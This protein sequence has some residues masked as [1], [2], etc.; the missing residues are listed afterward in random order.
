MSSFLTSESSGRNL[1]SDELIR[2]L[3][4]NQ[5]DESLSEELKFLE[6]K[7][8]KESF[9]KKLRHSIEII[10]D[11]IELTLKGNGER[12]LCISFNGGKDCCVVLFLFYKIALKTGFLSTKHQFN[13]LI[14]K[15]SE[16][17]K[18]MDEF[19]DKIFREFY[20]NKDINKIV[21]DKPGIKLK[22]CLELFKQDYPNIIHVLMGTRRTDNPYVAKLKDFNE[23]D[24]DWP[25]FIRVN[26]ILDWNY[27]EIWYFL[28]RFR[29]PYCPL[30]DHGYTS[31]GDIANTIRNEALFD[32]QRG[33]YKPAY[34][35]ENDYKERNSR[36]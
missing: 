1:F 20:T 3:T 23:T 33:T 5:N 12:E 24:S 8:D 13:I 29:V 31:L 14:M 36:I 6:A 4:D 15:L 28:K 26:P 2:N 10:L 9:N 34:M 7:I 11:A 18:E 22:K 30:Y 27:G 32:A 21:I 25:Y 16:S 19:I 35:L 17:F